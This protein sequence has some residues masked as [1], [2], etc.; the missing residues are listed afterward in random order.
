MQGKAAVLGDIDFV[1]PFAALGLD[2]FAV[3]ASGE[4]LVEKTDMVLA[5]DYAMIAVAENIAPGVQRLFDVTCKKALP[6][7]VVLPFTS[8]SQGFASQALGRLLKMATGIDIV[9]K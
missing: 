4:D 8:E 5:G 3:S 6:C 7:V 1:A 2:T 9:N